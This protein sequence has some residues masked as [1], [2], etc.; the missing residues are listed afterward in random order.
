MM[1]SQEKD[2][3][4]E[5]E[6]EE[7]EQEAEELKMIDELQ[8]QGIGMGDLNKLKSAGICTVMGVLMTHKKELLNIKG[9]SEQKIEKIMEAAQKVANAGF[10]SGLHYLHKRQKMV[11]I[12]TGS[13]N[14][15]KLLG[16][17]IE[18]QS[19][20]EAFGEFRTGKTQL[21]HTLCVTAQLPKN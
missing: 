3:E 2:E 6:A 8:L 7:V 9:I 18:T 5:Q 10:N 1:K 21:S 13:K 4:V 12:S 16:G 17:G 19:I 15:D 20:T 14:F 11:F